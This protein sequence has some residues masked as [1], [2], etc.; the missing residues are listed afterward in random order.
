MNDSAP[1]CDGN[2]LRAVV[3]AEFFQNIFNV[4]LDRVF[5][6]KEPI[7]DYFVAVSLRYQLQNFGFTR[8]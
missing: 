5:S 8:G 7:S 4:S 6:D 3:G 1:D 2:G